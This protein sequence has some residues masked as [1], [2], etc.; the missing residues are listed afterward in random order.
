MPRPKVPELVWEISTSPCQYC[1]SHWQVIAGPSLA[2]S[3][4][5]IRAARI[6]HRIR[7]ATHV[8]CL[9]TPLPP[10]LVLEPRLGS[11]CIR[12]VLAVWNFLLG[13]CCANLHWITR[14]SVNGLALMMRGNGLVAIFT[15]GVVRNAKEVRA[16]D[17]R[18]FTILYVCYL[19]QILPHKS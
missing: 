1:L 17:W 19:N 11:R 9:L 18:P 2:R 4:A 5:Y 7:A 12:T 13:F 14:R 10:S 3:S 8:A 16:S 6:A 15:K